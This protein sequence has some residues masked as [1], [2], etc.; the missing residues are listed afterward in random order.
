MN[1]LD[2]NDPAFHVVEE[3]AILPDDNKTLALQLVA[4]IATLTGWVWLM[5]KL[6]NYLLRVSVNWHPVVQFFF[7]PPRTIKR[8]AQQT[9]VSFGLLIIMLKIQNVVESRR[10]HPKLRTRAQDDMIDD[11]INNALFEL[12]GTVGEPDSR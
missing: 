3:G 4:A 11:I 2:I 1:A 9:T 7:A 6:R 12:D 5:R 8:W 10:E